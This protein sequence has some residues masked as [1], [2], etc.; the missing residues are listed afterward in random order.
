MISKKMILDSIKQL[1]PVEKLEVSLELQ[2]YLFETLNLDK[3]DKI[4]YNEMK[5]LLKRLRHE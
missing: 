3:T 2:I 5:E 4:F 1:E